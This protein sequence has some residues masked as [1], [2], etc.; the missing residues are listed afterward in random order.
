M[1]G[2]RVRAHQSVGPDKGVVPI[3]IEAVNFFI[4][5]QEAEAPSEVDRRHVARS[6][7]AD[8]VTVNTVLPPTHKCLGKIVRSTT[9]I[10]GL[11]EMLESRRKEKSGWVHR[12][13]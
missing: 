13:S 8:V 4:H 12:L 7:F 2:V 10:P 3:V 9:V 1:C 5:A 11:L 6:C